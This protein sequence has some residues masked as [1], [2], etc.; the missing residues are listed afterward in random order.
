MKSNLGRKPQFEDRVVLSVSFERKELELINSIASNASNYVRSIV[1]R[2]FK[3]RESQ[4]IKSSKINNVS[5]DN[6][7]S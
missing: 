5:N 3:S 2:E 7:S 6:K 1:I 4:K